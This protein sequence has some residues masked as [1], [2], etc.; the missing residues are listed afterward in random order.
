ML[1]YMAV[2]ENSSHMIWRV[3]CGGVVLFIVSV[4]VECVVYNVCFIFFCGL[5]SFF[6]VDFYVFILYVFFTLIRFCS[7]SGGAAVGC[8]CVGF[9]HI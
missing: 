1:S 6:L 2:L 5:P 7:A 8:A 9:L 4:R 3:G